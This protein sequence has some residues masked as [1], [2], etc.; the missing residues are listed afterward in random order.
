MQ[1]TTSFPLGEDANDTR[2][3]LLYFAS[4]ELCLNATD[5]IRGKQALLLVKDQDEFD[6]L[7]QQL[8]NDLDSVIVDSRAVGQDQ[9][10]ANAQEHLRLAVDALQAARDSVNSAQHPCCEKSAEYQSLQSSIGKAFDA[11]NA[12]RVAMYATNRSWKVLTRICTAMMGRWL[13][14]WNHSRWLDLIEHSDII[15]NAL[16]GMMRKLPAFEWTGQ[17]SFR[18]WIKRITYNQSVSY[19]RKKKKHEAEP[20]DRIDPNSLSFDADDEEFYSQR[21]VVEIERLLGKDAESLQLVELRCQQRMTFEE[22]SQ[23]M[24]ITAGSVRTRWYRLRKKIMPHLQF[25]DTQIVEANKPDGIDGQ[26]E[27]QGRI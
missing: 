1:N 16:I 23:Q 19:L 11:L 13:S 4:I 25:C 3:S 26:S 6:R 2:L 17:Y 12:A 27:K 8:A 18:A 7:R 10:N 5:R 20:L 15:Q 24:G 21:L 14:T 9:Q 22:I